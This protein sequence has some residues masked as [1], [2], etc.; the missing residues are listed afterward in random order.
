MINIGYSSGVKAV[1]TTY[2][3]DK[4]PNDFKDFAKCDVDAANQIKRRVERLRFGQMNFE[5]LE[6]LSANPGL[7]FEELKEMDTGAYRRLDGSYGGVIEAP[8]AAAAVAQ[9]PNAPPQS[10]AEG[11]TELEKERAEYSQQPTAAP[12][13]VAEAEA[14]MKEAEILTGGS[15][16][17]D[18]TQGFGM[19]K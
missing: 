17:P 10:P 6:Y 12:A 9:E 5:F 15:W 14:L 13:S 2:L 1:Y 18:N 11:G 3:K 7:S 4:D 8:R 19:P 16:D